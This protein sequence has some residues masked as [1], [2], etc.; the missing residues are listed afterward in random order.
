MTSSK[1]LLHHA[2]I[3]WKTVTQAT[4]V[5]A[6]HT[7]DLGRRMTEPSP[8]FTVSLHR[9]TSLSLAIQAF[10]IYSPS[11]PLGFSL[12]LFN[13][14]LPYA[15]PVHLPAHGVARGG[16]ITS[17]PVPVERRST[18]WPLPLA[19]T[20]GLATPAPGRPLMTPRPWPPKEQVTHD[21]R[22]W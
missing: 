21:S 14:A 9:C 22:H 12:F 10:N 2:Q 6:Y 5:A 11:L 15:Y 3:I 8:G 16:S 18:C 13:R 1:K 4:N 17:C 7:E 19:T 20:K